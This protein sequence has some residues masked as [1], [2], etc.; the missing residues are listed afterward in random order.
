MRK[1]RSLSF[2]M[3]LVTVFTVFSG[4]TSTEDAKQEVENNAIEVFTLPDIIEQDEAQETAHRYRFDISMAVDGWISGYYDQNKGI[5]L[6]PNPS[7]ESGSANVYK[8]FASYNR[9]SYKPSVMIVYRKPFASSASDISYYINSNG[10]SSD[11][12]LQRRANCYGFALKMYYAPQRIGDG[13]AGAHY[14]QQPGEFADKSAIE[15]VSNNID[16]LELHWAK[17]NRM[18]SPLI[19]SWIWSPLTCRRWDIACYRRTNTLRH[20]KSPVHP[21]IRTAD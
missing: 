21:R 7:V 1:V 5:I 13:S 9:A 4:F 10:L 3:A 20:H 17:S 19:L 16:L 18:P 2:L 15:G 8:T 14:K 11:D 6:I 12:N